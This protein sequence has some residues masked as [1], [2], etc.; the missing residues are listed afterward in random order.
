MKKKCILAIFLLYLFAVQAMTQEIKAFF[1]ADCEKALTEEISKA[2]KSIRVAIY[3]FT[4]FNIANALSKAAKNGVD[5]K[6]IMDKSQIEASEYGPKILEIIQKSKIE[7]LL[8]EKESQMHHK[9]VVIDKETV[10]TGSFNFTTS[11]AKF[12]DENLVIIKDAQTAEK[13]LKAWEGIF[14]KNKK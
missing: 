1:N 11:A 4:R 12:N 8:I 5:V 6:V 13:F 10:A 3:S 14:Q 9:F 7:V 2:K